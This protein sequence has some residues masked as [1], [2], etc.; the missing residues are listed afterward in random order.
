MKN[1]LYI[2]S[3]LLSENAGTPRQIRHLKHISEANSIV[4]V[5]VCDKKWI[6][7]D[8]REDFLAFLE[9]RRRARRQNS[10]DK[11]RRTLLSGLFENNKVKKLF[12]FCKNDLLF[13]FFTPIHLSLLVLIKN[14]SR[15][16][17]FSDIYIS[18]PPFPIF[19]NFIF[20]DNTKVHLDMRDPW[21]THPTMAKLKLHRRMLENRFLKKCN[22]ISVGSKHHSKKI[23]EVY[24]LE[25]EVIYNY[26]DRESND[27]SDVKEE[28]LNNLSQTFLSDINDYEV[29][30]YI[31]TTPEGFYNLKKIA[32]ILQQKLRTQRDLKLY[33]VGNNE[34]K[35]FF[36]NVFFKS[37]QVNFIDRVPRR[38]AMCYLHLCD[39]AMHFGHYFDGYPTT[40]LFELIFLNKPIVP[41]LVN[42]NHEPSELLE[43]HYGIKEPILDYADLE[44]FLAVHS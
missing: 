36:E 20:K 23:S 30:C 14:L 39:K 5:T 29:W 16:Y 42:Q 26:A 28:E 22:K 6:S 11:P 32:N 27:F 15:K 3:E 2:A 8:S 21:G 34:I 33:F 9:N 41:L 18:S 35:N 4:V 38:E 43:K 44:S 37:R 24:G 40:K 12:R 13:E 31:G 19:L 10:S 25:S 1:Y 7:F 17:K